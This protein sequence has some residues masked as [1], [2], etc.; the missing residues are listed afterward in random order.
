MSGK[1]Q[2]KKTKSEAKDV[3]AMTM[4]RRKRN[5]HT[6]IRRKMAEAHMCAVQWLE[7]YPSNCN[8]RRVCVFALIYPFC[9]QLHMGCSLRLNA[10]IAT[11]I[12]KMRAHYMP[13]IV[14]IYILYAVRPFFSLSSS[15]AKLRCASASRRGER[16]ML[17]AFWYSLC[18]H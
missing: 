2:L 16:E 14:S 7:M 10:A 3:E 12:H 8:P 6:R 17:F 13:D 5:T 4:Q 11:C 18:R 15:L 9:T 1:I